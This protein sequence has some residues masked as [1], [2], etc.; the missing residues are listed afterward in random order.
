MSVAEKDY[1][2]PADKAIQLMNREN[3][4]AFG[5]LKMADFDRINVIRIVLELYREQARKAKKRYLEIGLEA[6]LL[7]LALAD[8][9]VPEK[10]AG[11][12]AKKA[13]TKEWVE[14]LMKATDFVTLYRFNSEMERKAQRLVEGL[15]VVGDRQSGKEAWQSP[16]ETRNALIDQALKQWSKQLG[17]YA[18]NVTD[19]AV[20][21]AFDDAGVEWVEW[22]T[23]RDQKVCTD[24]HQLDGR[25]F[26]IEEVPAKPHWN[27]RCRLVPTGE[28]EE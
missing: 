25:V 17:Q 2:G 13:I 15:A 14:D 3:L 12:M 6:Y 10:K 5:R 22:V 21:Q 4:R 19:A 1:Y 7:G 27:C 23:E 18:I 26:R 20:L 24:C 28:P 8:E 9:D 11:Q 16:V